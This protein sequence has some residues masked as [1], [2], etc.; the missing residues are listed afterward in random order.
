MNKNKYRHREV[1]IH[2][3]TTHAHKDKYFDFILLPRKRSFTLKQFRCLKNLKIIQ[4]ICL[5]NQSVHH[6]QL[7]LC[8]IHTVG[9]STGLPY[10]PSATMWKYWLKVTVSQI[11]FALTLTL[12][13][14]ELG[15]IQ[16]FTEE[17][18]ICL[19]SGSAGSIADSLE[20]VLLVLRAGWMQARSHPETT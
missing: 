4:K 11:Q 12:K 18:V 10:K 5:L 6:P 15:I 8:C 7:Y 19:I 2:E 9:C 3:C 1:Q 13:T 20:L 16:V 17:L 14:M